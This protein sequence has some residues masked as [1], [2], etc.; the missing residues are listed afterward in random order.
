MVPKGDVGNTGPKGDVG[1]T[2]PIGPRGLQGDSIIGPQGPQG[3][4]GDSIVGPQGTEGPQGQFGPRGFQGLQGNTGNTGPT[5][6]QGIQGIQGPQ[7]L[8]GIKGDI[9]NTGPQGL[10][11]AKGDIG[12]T[13]SQ[14]IKG[15]IGNTGPQGNSIVGPQGPRGFNGSD[16]LSIVGPAGV[17]PSNVI[18][19]GGN[20]FSSNAVIGTKDYYA[21][22]FTTNGMERLSILPSGDLRILPNLGLRF[23]DS[24][25]T[26]TAAL[27]APLNIPVSYN[28]TLPATVGAAETVLTT[29]ATGSTS[30]QPKTTYNSSTSSTVFTTASQTDDMVTGMILTAAKAGMYTVHFA[31]TVSGGAAG[32][33]MSV[34]L[35]IAN[36]KQ[37]FTEQPVLQPRVAPAADATTTFVHGVPVTIACLI[38]LNTW[39]IVDVRMRTNQASAAT[40]NARTFYIM[41]VGP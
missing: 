30:W 32:A 40:M 26:T 34:T 39:D 18:V 36:V 27:R 16:G 1:N 22:R 21:L 25:N 41:R 23:T 15:D 17:A 20:A 2:G 8:Q 38:R 6:S 33:W 3:M 9:G 4:Q 29:D 11:G 31:S 13:G 14:G 5:G 35:Y 24:T 19:Q 37:S 10:Q 28:I 7:G 12:N